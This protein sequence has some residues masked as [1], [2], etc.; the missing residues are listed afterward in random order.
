MH[1]FVLFFL[2]YEKLVIG[3]DLKIVKVEFTTEGRKVPLQKI[4]Q[5]LLQK[6]APF[7]RKN[8][9]N[10]YEMSETEVK[11]RLKDLGEHKEN[12]NLEEMKLRLTSYETT[13]HLM[14]WLDNSTVANHGY[15]LCLV[16]CLYDPAVFYTDEEYKALKGKDVDIQKEI[17]KPEVHFIAR[18]SSGDEEQL[19]Y[20]ETRLECVQQ[21]KSSIKIGDVEYEDKMRFF[22]GDNPARAHEA[23]QQKGGNYFCS[24]CEVHSIMTDDVTHILNCKIVTLEERQESIMSGKISLH[25]SKVQKTKPLSGLKKHELEQELASRGIYDG[26]RKDELQ[27]LLNKEMRGKQRVPALLFNN[28]QG[29]LSELCLQDYEILPCEPLHDVGHHIENVFT[30]LPFHLKEQEAKAIEESMDLCLGSKDS[31]R[32]ADYRSALVK[33]AGYIM[34]H[35]IMSDKPLAIINSLVEMQRILYAPDSQRS[36]SLILRYCNQSWL[37]SILLAEL[38]Q[39]PKKLTRRKLFGVYFHNLSAHAS[40]M[41]RLISGQASN[42][43]QQERMFNHVKRITRSTS[44]YHAEQIIPNLFVRLQAEKEMSLHS[45]DVSQQQAEIS[46]LTRSLPP[47]ANTKISFSFIQRYRG[48][49]QAHLQRISDFLLEGKGVWWKR[50][51]KN[52]VFNDVVDCPSI[53]DHG[54]QLHH[55]RSRSLKEEEAYLLECWRQC[56]ANDIPIPAEAIKI[57]DEKEN[58]VSTIERS[59]VQDENTTVHH[60]AAAFTI[61]EE[62]HLAPPETILDVQLSKDEIIILEEAEI[63]QTQDDTSTTSTQQRDLNPIKPDIATPKDT[64]MPHQTCE[65]VEIY[66][67]QTRLAKAIAVVLGNIKEVQKLD[68]RRCALKDILKSKK[69]MGKEKAIKNYES[70][71]V[72][73]QTKVLAEKSKVKE[74]FD[75]WEKAY[76]A[77]NQ[78]AATYDVIKNDKLA[79]VLLKKIKYADAILKEGMEI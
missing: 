79:S 18:C 71:L 8:T 54:P 22:H 49:W 70:L 29:R 52:I 40:L 1:G 66:P 12:E 16:T 41:L 9:S 45:D 7:L 6:H 21:L 3:K 63:S 2:Q 30:E 64:Q 11:S 48:A 34:Q 59:L 74:Q 51:G 50:D 36:P 61:D 44:N 15:L 10:H 25:N 68:R 32:T 26:G 14:I 5:D 73:L 67:L 77:E 72:P 38:V 20:S 58:T 23:G 35:H 24:T 4:R 46:Y 19:T 17:E 31:K 75:K 69:D 76:Y 43:E 57:D 47:P 53:A 60:P 56:L 42:A 33:T 62:D 37:H 39:K 78:K 28:P 27:S 55:F 13:R 65:T